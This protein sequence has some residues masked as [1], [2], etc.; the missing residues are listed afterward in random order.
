MLIDM[1]AR[2]DIYIIGGLSAHDQA[3]LM[4]WLRHFQAAPRQTFL[5]LGES[6]NAA[7]LAEVIQQQLKWNVRAPAQYT[8]VTF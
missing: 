3:G 2:A 4:G 8:T 7:A 1:P 5:V 6:L